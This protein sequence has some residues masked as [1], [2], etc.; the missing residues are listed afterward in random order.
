[1]GP[2]GHALVSSAV[3]VGVWAVTGSPAAAGVTVAVGVL[4]DAD[5]VYDYYQ[6]YARGID[7]KL[8]VPLHAW[9]YSLVGLVF[10]TLGLDHPMFLGAVLAHLAHVG[11]DHWHN[12]LGRFS[13]SITYRAIKGF[14]FESIAGQRVK[15][16]P[17]HMHSIRFAFDRK[18]SLWVQA[19]ARGW[20]LRQ[21]GGKHRH[22]PSVRQADD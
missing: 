6:R 22:E 8:Y 16:H 20:M 14:D 1:M 18:L 3:G 2:I 9:E 11:S 10:M 12:G 13:Y 19:K 4:M 7:G 15:A 17:D 21:G 5:H